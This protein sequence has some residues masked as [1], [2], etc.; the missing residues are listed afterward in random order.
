[1]ERPRLGL[2]LELELE[3]INLHSFEFLELE[4]Y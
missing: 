2:E 4:K 1:M 3:F